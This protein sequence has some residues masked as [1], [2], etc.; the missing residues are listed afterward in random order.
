MTPAGERPSVGQRSR[1]VLS[2]AMALIA[3]VVIAWWDTRPSWDDTGVTAGLL[4]TSSGLAAYAGVRPWLAA[5]L[6]AG[7]ILVA[8]LRPSAP[9]VLLAGA[10]T[11]V[12]AFAGAALREAVSRL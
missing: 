12:A 7:P 10:I 5:A 4:A 1:R 2:A 11:F 3:G 6:V 8:E 9:G